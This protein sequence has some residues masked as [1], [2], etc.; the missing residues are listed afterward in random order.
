[1]RRLCCCRTVRC[2]W[3]GHAAGFDGGEAK[4]AVIFRG[5]ASKARESVVR[6]LVLQVLWVRVFPVRIGL[7]YLDDAIGHGLSVAI[8]NA[9]SDLDAFARDAG[10][11]EIIAVKP[12]QSDAEEGADR[13]PGG[14]LQLHFRAP[15]ECGWS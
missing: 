12:A 15:C 14:C 8:E 7:P 3:S 4:S 5:H 13:L 10:A 9:P 2:V 1:M 6:G 11:G